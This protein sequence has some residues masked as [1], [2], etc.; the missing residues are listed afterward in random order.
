M[1]NLITISGWIFAVVI[2]LIYYLEIQTPVIKSKQYN[3]IG[4]V[5]NAYI[6]EVDIPLKARVDSGAGV[7]SL[8]AKII[9]IHKSKKKGKPDQVTF[10]IKN[11]AGEVKI[12]TKDVIEWMRI[13]KIGLD[14]FLS[15][16]VVKMKICLGGKKISGRVNLS[17]R[18]QFIYPVLI[19]RN[20]LKTGDFLVDPKR[21]FT[22]HHGCK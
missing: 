15:R 8:D 7:T 20:F 6:D 18:A 13:K 1:K 14:E 21:K 16:P 4:R 17:D 22:N 11:D 12:L 10:E 5:E 2:G 9:E 19:G 3:V